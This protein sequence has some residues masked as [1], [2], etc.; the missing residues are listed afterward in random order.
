[1][2]YLIKNSKKFKNFTA[3]FLSYLMFQF[4]FIGCTEI[5]SDSFEIQNY[6]TQ[7]YTSQVN[8]EV[9]KLDFSTGNLSQKEFNEIQSSLN[10]EAKNN[11]LSYAETMQ[12]KNF[13]V[14]FLTSSESSLDAELSNTRLQNFSIDRS[15]ALHV[16]NVYSIILNGLS[17]K[18]NYTEAENN[19]KKAYEY[20]Y[21]IR[22]NRTQKLLIEQI[23]Q[24]QHLSISLSDKYESVDNKAWVKCK[25]YQWICVAGATAAAIII[26]AASSGAAAIILGGVS[27]AAV[28]ACCI[29]R[30][31]CSFSDSCS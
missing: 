4:S 21:T 17:E 31:K 10:L 11:S 26:I 16:K 7:N 25:W 18:S 27:V 12:F 8:D 20:A 23:E 14:N 2:Y 22:D 13:M 1:M 28:A 30:C 9:L 24:T 29:C 15:I 5:G 3:L 19:F 6:E